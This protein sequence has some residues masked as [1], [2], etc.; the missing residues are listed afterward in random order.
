[1]VLRLL[2]LRPGYLSTGADNRAQGFCF[3]HPIPC[4]GRIGTGPSA[5][6]ILC[7]QGRERETKGQAGS[8]AL[9]RSLPFAMQQLVE[10]LLLQA[11][12]YG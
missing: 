12:G 6:T 11:Q 8:I 1:M 9:H 5:S 7:H 10:L 2:L 4:L 3:A